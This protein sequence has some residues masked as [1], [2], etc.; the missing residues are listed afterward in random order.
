MCYLLLCIPLMFTYCRNESIVAELIIS[1]TSH[2]IDSESIFPCSSLNIHYISRIFLMKVV[3]LNEI[4][5][6]Y[7]TYY[8]LYKQFLSR[9]VKF[10]LGFMYRKVQNWL[11][12]TNISFTWQ[13]L[14]WTTVPNFIEI[15]WVVSDVKYGEW[16]T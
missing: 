1:H 13:I 4:Y 9:F 6:F 2:C 5:I 7:I 12:H 15:N 11:Q 3:N 10:S 14:V 16:W 8:F